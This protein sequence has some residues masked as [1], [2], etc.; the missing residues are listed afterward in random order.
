M[1]TVNNNITT[2]ESKGKKT[3]GNSRLQNDR[4]KKFEVQ[5]L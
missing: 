5:N 4:V 3:Q 1:C 2:P